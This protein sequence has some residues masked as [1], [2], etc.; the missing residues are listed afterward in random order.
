ML[1]FEGTCSKNC[2]EE[3]G[4]KMYFFGKAVLLE[5]LPGTWKAD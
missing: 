3:L 4:L 5:L 1:Y 2:D